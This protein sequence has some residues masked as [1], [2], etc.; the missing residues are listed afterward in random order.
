MCKSLAQNDLNTHKLFL[1]K[2]QPCMKWL[3][4]MLFG[5]CFNSTHTLCANFFE[6]NI[7]IV[8]IMDACKILS[9]QQIY[10]SY[11]KDQQHELETWHT[12]NEKQMNYLSCKRI[13]EGLA[14]PSK[15]STMLPST[16]ELDPL[17]LTILSLSTRHWMKPLKSLMNLC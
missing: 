9:I 17:V 7:F 8:H 5:L 14:L 6:S 1:Y 10:C 4:Y 12:P 13:C 11:H 2:S 16:H 3:S 15:Y